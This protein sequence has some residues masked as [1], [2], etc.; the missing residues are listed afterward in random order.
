MNTIFDYLEWRGDLPISVVPF[1]EVDAAILARFAYEPLDNAAPSDFY[2]SV[3]IKECCHKLM[4]DPDIDIKVISPEIDKKLITMMYE[5]KR[6]NGMRICGFVNEIDL[7]R[8]T[9]FAA[10]VFEMDD[11]ANYYL[12]FRGTDNTI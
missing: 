2:K 7:E 9:Q 1:N 8:Q 5:S 10:M 12:A 4:N 3:T 6:F 11:E